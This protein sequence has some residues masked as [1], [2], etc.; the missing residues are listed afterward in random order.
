MKAGQS[1]VGIGG[2]ATS[3]TISFDKLFAGNTKPDSISFCLTQTIFQI[4]RHFLYRNEY[5]RA[6][7]S[8]NIYDQMLYFSY[9]LIIMIITHFNT[10]AM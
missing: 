5:H 8:I 10:E 6:I 9:W 3:V 2:P 4:S 7:V 1:M